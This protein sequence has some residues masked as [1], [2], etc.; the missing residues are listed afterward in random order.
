M[1]SAECIAVPNALP[2]AH[3]A[4][5]Q[6]LSVSGDLVQLAEQAVGGAAR[7]EQ[8][9]HGIRARVQAEWQGRVSA[10]ESQLEAASNPPPE[11]L[12]AMVDIDKLRNTNQGLVEQ[13]ESQAQQLEK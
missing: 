5:H 11:L 10:L 6:T 8:H 3:A 4:A 1:Q 13:M 12:E 9:A 2:H 7:L